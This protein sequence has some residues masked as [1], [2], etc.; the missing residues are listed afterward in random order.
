MTKALRKI[1]IFLYPKCCKTL[2]QCPFCRI[3]VKVL[4]VRYMLEA[5]ESVQRLTVMG[6]CSFVIGKS[7]P[8][9]SCGSK[10]LVA[11]RR[12]ENGTRNVPPSHI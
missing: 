3:D 11:G 9:S 2:R 12:W 5:I 1:E 7:V 6:W 8:E 4:E 10:S